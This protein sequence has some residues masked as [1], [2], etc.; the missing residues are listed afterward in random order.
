MGND[1]AVEVDDVGGGAGGEPMEAARVSVSRNKYGGI[2]W[3]IMGAEVLGLVL[4][5]PII[6][7]WGFPLGMRTFLQLFVENIGTGELTRLLVNG[8]SV[9]VVQRGKG[10]QEQEGQESLRGF[11]GRHNYALKS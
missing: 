5:I 4:E 9:E 7:L 2:Y 1:V 3:I 6:L 8:L 11:F 10:D